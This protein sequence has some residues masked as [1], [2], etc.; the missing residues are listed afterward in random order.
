MEIIDVNEPVR[1]VR[2]D[3]VEAKDGFRYKDSGSYVYCVPMS[4]NS[5]SLDI[6]RARDGNRFTLGSEFVLIF[7]PRNNIAGFVKADKMVVPME[8]ILNAAEKE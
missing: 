5:G 7:N 2:A 4:D 6:R 1:E 3:S 8:F